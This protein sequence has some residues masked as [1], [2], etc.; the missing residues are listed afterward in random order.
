MHKTHGHIVALWLA[1]IA[2]LV[3][4]PATASAAYQGYI[5]TKGAKQGSFKG[6]SKSVQQQTSP[7]TSPIHSSAP[8]NSGGV[9]HK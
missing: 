3:L 5:H 6:Q 8:N 4:V 9:R 1:A 7:M 2:L